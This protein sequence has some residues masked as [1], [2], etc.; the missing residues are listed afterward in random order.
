MDRSLLYDPKLEQQH[1]IL[2]VF[3]FSV[4]VWTGGYYE[5]TDIVDLYDIINLIIIIIAG[6]F[7]LNFMLAGL[8]ATKILHFTAR[9]T[10]HIHLLII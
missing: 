3:Y 6:S 2:I 4:V 1:H 10:L 8:S 7:L 5:M 9:L